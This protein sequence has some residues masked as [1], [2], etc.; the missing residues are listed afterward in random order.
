MCKYVGISGLLI[1]GIVVAGLGYYVGNINAAPKRIEAQLHHYGHGPVQLQRNHPE[2]S[3][4]S[5]KITENPIPRTS[6]VIV[7]PY[8][9]TKTYKSGNGDTVKTVTTGEKDG[10][11]YKIVKTNFNVNHPSTVYQSE[12]H[13]FALENEQIQKR[14][15]DIAQQ[16]D[17][18]FGRAPHMEVILEPGP[19]INKH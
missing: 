19:V 13:R 1:A 10:V 14:M 17:K 15:N 9:H 2:F 11:Q 6:N 18:E 12:M 16:M 5:T 4:Y 7:Q 8:E 3:G